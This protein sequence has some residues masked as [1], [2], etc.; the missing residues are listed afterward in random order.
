M[1]T[2]MT[3]DEINYLIKVLRKGTIASAARK[4]CLRRA[5][6][7]VLVKHAKNGK[8]IYKFYWQC[9]KC[10]EW[11][12]DVTA[13]EVDH[14]EEIGPFKGDWHDFIMRM[15]FCGQE[16]LQALCTVCHQK[17]TS[18]GNARARYERKICLTDKR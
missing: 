8:P 5:R 18:N 10:R 12:R 16:N 9:A 11:W 15:Y 1:K 14:I 13:L 2:Y 6:K 3:K 4:E 7:K 17:K